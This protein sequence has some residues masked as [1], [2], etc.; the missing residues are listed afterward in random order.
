M[1]TQVLLLVLCA[2]VGK[3]V[4]DLR[5][6]AC[7]FSSVDSDRSCLTVTN[8]TLSVDCPYQYC[9]IMRQEFMDPIGEVASFTRGCEESPDYLN[10]DITD[11]TFRTYYRACTSDLCNIGDGIQSVVGGSLNPNPEYV[12]DN[13]LVPGTRDGATTVKIS[14]GLILSLLIMN[15]Y[16]Q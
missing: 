6:Y 14:S 15:L 5:C 16:C 9:T 10:H 11:S 7:T 4:G 13:L 3:S 1:Y 2:F 12:G 8:D